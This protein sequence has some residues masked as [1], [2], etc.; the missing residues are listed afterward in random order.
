MQDGQ[1]S[2]TLFEEQLNNSDWGKFLPGTSTLNPQGPAPKTSTQVNYDQL[3]QSLRAQGE[4]VNKS[5]K[6]SPYKMGDVN[7]LSLDLTGR[8]TRQ[9]AGADNEDLWAQSQT[10]WDKMANGLL[11]GL[12]LASTTFVQGTLG[13]VYGTAAAIGEGEFNK[14]YNN[15]LSNALDE[16]NKEAE[17]SLPNYYT[18]RERAA[19]WWEPSNLFTANFLWDKLVK[20]LGFSVGAIASGYTV[21]GAI[22]LVPEAFGLS[23]AG[24]LASV[25]DGMEA[26]LSAVP[27]AQRLNTAKNI[28]LNTSKTVNTLNKALSP[29]DRFT[30]STLGAV[31]EGGI[32]ALQGI[33]QWREEK[34]QEYKDTY[35]TIPIGEAMDKI[36][37]TAESLGNARMG[38][39]IALLT[40]T[41]YIQLP[42]IL[43]SSYKESKIIANG[44]ER[45]IN[46]IGRNIETG[47]FEAL[48]PTSRTGKFMFRA[49]NVASL[50]FSPSEA[51]EEGA[52]NVI[53]EGVQDYY[54][55]AYRG[56]GRD[57]L[58]SISEGWRR[59]INDKSGLEQILIG[60]LSGGLQQARGNIQERGV[61]GTGGA[62]KTHTNDFLSMLNSSKDT[63]SPDGWMQAMA[64]SAARG[65]NLQ[66]EG[67]KYVRQGDL[68]E[69]KDNEFDYQHNYLTPR[70]KYGR[71]DLVMDDINNYKQLAASPE[72]WNKL[73]E[74]GI[75]NEG[76]SVQTF[77]SRLS[78]FEQ[79]AK[80]V[81]SLYQSLN[82]R[83]GGLVDKETK[84]PVYSGEAIEKMVYAASKVADYDSR[85]PQVNSSLVER[86][87]NTQDVID[88]IITNNRVSEKD[89]KQALDQI[90]SLNV[91]S[92]IKDQLKSDLRDVIE[93][94]LR[95]KGYMKAY[96][97]LK[98]HPS[99]YSGESTPDFNEG[100]KIGGKNVEIGKEYSISQ[101]LLREG[102]KLSLSP[103]LTVLSSTLNGELEVKTPTGD[104][105]YKKP[106]Q[107]NYQLSDTPQTPDKA[108]IAL[109]D[110]AIDKVLGKREDLPTIDDKL[111]FINSQNDK[112]L[113]DE[114]EAQITKDTK[115]YVENQK[116]IKAANEKLARDKQLNDKLDKDQSLNSPTVESQNF[117]TP[118]DLAALKENP[119]AP[120]PSFL[121]K[122]A[123]FYNPEA[124]KPHQKRR[125]QFLTLLPTFTQSKAA[126]INVL[127]ISQANEASYGLSGLISWVKQDIQ[128][129]KFSPEQRDHYLNQDGSL[130]ESQEPIVKLYTIKEGNT[131]YLINSEGDKLSPLEGNILP[132]LLSDGVFGLFHSDVTGTYTFGPREGQTNYSGNYSQE[133]VNS[134]QKQ[135]KEWR[136]K[137]LSSKTSPVYPIGNISLGVVLRDDE[138]KPV[139]ETS[140]VT[141][142]DILNKDNIITV[143]TIGGLSVGD[144]SYNF[145][146]GVPLLTNGANVDFLNNRTFTPQEAENVFKLIR[147]RVEHSNTPTSERIENY[148]SSIL[149]LKS[150]R[151]EGEEYTNSQIFHK[152]IDGRRQ[153]FFGTDLQ[154]DFNTHALDDKKEQI[155]NYLS[156]YFIKINNKILT[157]SSSLGFEE[158]VPKEGGSV[159][160]VKH[161]SYQYFLLSTKAHSTPIL[162]TKAIRSV[163]SDDPSI[164]HRYTTLKAT[165]FEFTSS[166][167]K[168]DADQIPA[169][170]MESV[171]NSKKTMFGKKKAEEQAKPKKTED[172]FSK[173]HQAGNLWYG[174]FLN[175]RGEQEPVTGTSEEAVRNEIA[176][177][178]G[179]AP[180]PSTKEKIDQFKDKPPSIDKSEF[181]F[182]NPAIDYSPIDIDKELSYIEERSPFN[183]RILDNI[184]TTTDGLFAWGSYKDMLISLYNNAKA[185]TGYHELFEGVWKAFTTPNQKVQILKEFRSRKGSFSTFDGKEY[186]YIP[187]SEASDWQAKESLANEFADYILSKQEPKGSKILEWFKNLWNLIKSIF[188]GDVITIDKLFKNIDAGAYKSASSLY[189][190]EQTEYSLATLPYSDQY[191]TIRGVALA[192]VQQAINPNNENSISLTEWEESGEPSKKIYD[193]VYATLREFYEED[194]YTDALGFNKNIPLLQQYENYWTNIKES[195]PQ[196]IEATNEYLKSFGIIQGVEDENGNISRFDSDDYS[197]RDYIDDRKYFM[198]DARNT[199]SR[200]I[201][202][203]FATLP[204]TIFTAS[205]AIQSKRTTSTLM[206]EQVNYAKTFN[207]VLT[208]LIPYNTYKDKMA[209]LE[210]LSNK[211][212]NFKRLFLRL[213]TPSNTSNP[214]SVLN[215]WK[216]KTRFYQ[217]M[218]KQAPTPWIQY[219]QADGTSYTQ[220]A[221][222]ESSKKLIVQSWIDKMKAFALSGNNNIFT[223]TS[224][225]ELILKT[226]SLKHTIARPEDKFKFLSQLGI[227]F[228]KEM[229]DT[230]DRDMAKEFNNAVAGLSHQLSKNQVYPLEN[231]KSLNSIRNLETIAEA[232][233][234][235]G[236]D[237]ETSFYNID[238]ERQ[239]IQIATN[240]VSRWVNDINNSETKQDLLKAMPQLSQISDSLYLNSILYNQ[241]GDK[242]SFT[243]ELGYVQGTI[244]KNNKPIPG[245]S[246]PIFQRLQQ[247]INQNLSQRYYVLIPA[248]SK[249]QWMLSLKNIIPY[250]N[251]STDSYSKDVN[252]IFS[253]YYEIEK[254]EYQSL[255]N[256]ESVQGVF[257]DISNNY[258]LSTEEFLSSLNSFFNAQVNEQQRLLSTYRVL[259]RTKKEGQY[260]WN[261]LDGEFAKSAN[262][263]PKA[264]EDKTI[265]NILL[266]R[267]INYAINNIEMHKLF[268]GSPLAYKDAKR[269][270]LFLSPREISMYDTPEFNTFLNENMNKHTTNPLTGQWKFSDYMATIMMDDVTAYNE[271][272][273]KLSPDYKKIVATDAQ[274]WSTLPAMR[275]RR[276]KG[277]AW[278]QKDEEQYQYSQALDRQL[279][280]KDGILQ[281]TNPKSDNYYPSQIKT[282]DA[283][284]VEKGN[285]SSSY[286]YV[287]K[288]ILSGHVQ[289]DGKWS[290]ITDKFSI[291]SFS[292]ASIRNTNFREHYIK[293]L[294]QGIGYSIV[295]SGRKVGKTPANQFYTPDGDVNKEPYIGI[296][297]VPF[298]AFGVQTDTSG[299]KE[300]Q[301]RGSQITKLVVVNLYNNGAPLS[302]K[303]Q[304]LAQENMALLKEQ[305]KI[306]YDKLL[307]QIGAE[308]VDGQ[309]KIVDKRKITT[310]L[311][312]ELLKREVAESIKQLIGV[313]ED[314]PSQLIIPFEALPNYIQIKNILY[315]FVDKYILRPKVSGAP[316]VQVSGAL[317]EKYGVKKGSVNNKD[318]YYSSSLHF[319]TKEEP[320]ID[321]LLPAWAHKKLKQAGLKW[322]STEELYSLFKDSPD[323]KQLLSGVGFRIPTQE[324]NSIENMRISGFLPEE[325]GD[326]IVV[327]EEITTKAGSDFDIDKLNT[328]LQNIYVDN[329]K[330][331]R[332]VPYF[333]VGEEAK[334][335]LKRWAEKDIITDWLLNIPANIKDVNQEDYDTYEDYID[336]R[337]EAQFSGVN[338]TKEGE[339]AQ[340]DIDDLYRQSIENEYYRNMMELLSLPENFE[341]LITPNTSDTLKNIRDQLVELSPVFDSN[342]NP[343]I[344][345]P[346]YMLK[347]RHDLLSVKQMRAISVV[348]QTAI[349]T[350]Q[351]SKITIDPSRLKNIRRRDREYMSPNPRPL[352]PHNTIDGLSTISSI[353]DVE[354]N[355]I[356]DNNSQLINGTVDVANDAFLSQINY[357]RWTS[358]IF[359]LMVRLGM[360][361]STKHPI[362]TFFL[363]Q[364]IIRHYLGLLEIGNKNFIIDNT[365]IRQTMQRFKG[366]S[367][368]SE[369]PASLSA[370]TSL[371]EDNIKKYYNGVELSAQQKGEQILIFKEFLKYAQLANQL[372]KFQQGASWDTAR[373]ND[374]NSSYFKNFQFERANNNIFSDIHSYVD[375][376]HL[377][378]QRTAVLD[379]NSVM[380]EILPVQSELVQNTLSPIL[381]RVAERYT[382][383][384]SKNKI[385]RKMEESLLNYLIQTKTGINNSLSHMLV[386]TKTALVNQIKNI[387]KLAPDNDDIWRNTILQQLIPY[388]RGKSTLSTKNI[389]L[390]VKPRDVYSKNLYNRAFQ[391]LYDNPKT[392]EL[393]HS[394]VTLSFLQNGVSSSRI[395]FKDAIPAKLYSDEVNKAIG[396]LQSPEALQSFIDTGAFYKNNWND[397][398]IVPSIYNSQYP[399]GG[400]KPVSDY[401]SFLKAEGVIPT[402]AKN[403]IVVWV[404]GYNSYAPFL[405]HI[406][407]EFDDATGES[408]TLKTLLQ[409]V[410][411]SSGDGVVREIEDENGETQRRTLFIQTSALGDGPRA[412]EYYST[413]HS[414]VL[415]NGYTNPDVNLNVQSLYD[416]IISGGVIEN[417]EDDQEKSLPLSQNK[418][419]VEKII[420]GG[421][422]GV[423]VAGLDA[424][425]ELGIPTGGTAAAK[426]QQSIEGNKK[427]FNK[428]LATKYGLREGKIIR[429]EGMYGQY[430]DVYY[431]RTIDNAQEADGTIWF[432]N[433]SSPGGKLTLGA[434]AQRKKPKPL[435]NPKT[436]AE[437]Q[438]WVADNNIR[439]LNVAGNREHTNPGIYEKAKSM[440]IEAL[441]KPQ[442]SPSPQAGEQLPLFPE[443]GTE[444]KC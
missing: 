97:E 204:E 269:W 173:I 73:K 158:A 107:L 141:E 27:Q 162:Q 167:P 367:S 344:I 243:T 143:P 126:K 58:N 293:M 401:T 92:E 71:F 440:L 253:K 390:A 350:S 72:G 152:F 355:F 298:S 297:P 63:Q 163:A 258:T 194:I 423:D 12:S 238:G 112:Q 195:W 366:G 177:K 9:L 335:K 439:I 303:I 123:D 289:I 138:N 203:L 88:G 248:D 149:F 119:K 434:I 338:F 251:I 263:N 82:L 381:T 48:S 84:T 437:I 8:Y 221:N 397:E 133:D 330:Q 79:H 192:A 157:S 90:N 184:I 383:L 363:N 3:A 325:F 310:M 419:G 206:Q 175:S 233:I 364:P 382:S 247:E 290:P 376:S 275:E 176:K 228:T 378:T 164:I 189:T 114:L 51:F 202:L 404:S 216:L 20:N 186:G 111:S 354:S 265:K 166:A 319:Y 62:R 266:F 31:T 261:G 242:T 120:L 10:F 178:S 346:V 151:E 420:S 94:S 93:L 373:F 349:A 132:Q 391:E 438:K 45:G 387:K 396:E 159:E 359:H 429:R 347:S 171:F 296:T 288:P 393:A 102:N 52:Q 110:K 155:L 352:L 302:D 144:V 185:G 435:I 201:K 307:K 342:A 375:N 361:N 300:S 80:N 209:K 309:Y 115:Q 14:L 357:T 427:I 16:W 190:D 196:I 377:G 237:F 262:L 153:Y 240:A 282:H 421:Q 433:A 125:L 22:K 413:P 277:G 7:P 372:F 295:S 400:F 47:A 43:S 64:T 255:E 340:Q 305:T 345:S 374:P 313:K 205:G 169:E 441:S 15:E 394:L 283:A 44:V 360:A 32:E 213:T 337:T 35:G 312:N 254:A 308:D 223:I 54:N 18:A 182:L 103:S 339:K 379:S 116:K 386:D 389:T 412:Q 234:A 147:Y 193:D 191:S 55:K 403:P 299:K 83:Y 241:K 368:T 160:F 279:M 65:I 96:D 106:S 41:N 87:I 212:S 218:A 5:A 273:S 130:K 365:L 127:A 200:S 224:G 316:K 411:S 24:T 402:T 239:T 432:G 442:V 128:N 99:K 118:E 370:I 430:D 246:L 105:T 252:S 70:I 260:S 235:S 399:I 89:T 19:D 371:L 358:P 362:I 425:I 244:D 294:K 17:N 321:V 68:L 405:T 267:T 100:V 436:A 276:L 418:K 318:V 57:W 220:T 444:G 301:T 431:Q 122:E 121:S 232:S 414:S 314:D 198:N 284:L 179:K 2:N 197:N 148:L 95:R 230:L 410:Q 395:S 50:F 272:L 40:A 326:T 140:L 161:P 36:N 183:T 139:T 331:I 245:S 327:P 304:S 388:I 211:F 385:A 320:W 306:G 11:K 231:A 75:A 76:D 117:P 156:N 113:T 424:A 23:K 322:S 348:S 42:R 37:D 407:Q 165:E 215:D 181:S 187:Y 104:V 61:L 91:I 278:F 227:T 222:L 208:Q 154:V 86:N 417:V 353:K 286:I 13:L 135:H 199:A 324:L 311:K 328:Y 101:P 351:L 172:R 291:A 259:E 334:V 129:T 332:I 271:E 136:D 53:Q 38:M 85:I 287:E 30:I 142:E 56:E 59:T 415:Y 124:P 188:S 443:E 25:A 392:K 1:V 137:I 264:I 409:R 343:T 69:A 210:E 168:L 207:S 226:A 77:L 268:F 384:D 39:N 280:F 225:G 46:P 336:A 180:T 28:I 214:E 426:F 315:S 285:P 249:T 380:S 21:A 74:M 33:N 329:N 236:A 108:Y 146:P 369:F 333:G 4:A 257:R 217:V 428:E 109:V 219:N 323:A 81:N 250:K 170:R 270:K 341:R 281:D 274:A 29:I 256:K 145:T 416:Y 292:Y 67:Q 408:S 34:I 174:Y 134:I 406:W 60:G 49:K 98:E 66:I 356:T 317:M 150:P 131:L 26:S 422:T 398:A 229:Y 6:P 78:Q